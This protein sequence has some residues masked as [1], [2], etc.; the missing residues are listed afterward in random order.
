MSLWLVAAALALTTAAAP[1]DLQRAEDL[2]AK[3]K[4]ADASKALAKARQTKGLDRPSLLRILELQGIVAGQLRQAGP[5]LEAFKQL[6]VLDPTHELDA[7]YAP[8][9]TTPFMEAGQFVTEQGSLEVRAGT[10][11]TTATAV[12]SISVQVGRDPLKL[13]RSVVFHVASPG[14]WKVTPAELTGGLATLAVDGAEVSWWAELLGDNDAQLALVGSEAHPQVIAPPPP[15]ALT[16]TITPPLPPLS[17]SEVRA[18]PGAPIRTASYFV[19]GGAVASAGVG[20]FFGIKSQGEYSQLA[21]AERDMNGVIT[22]LTEQQ[23][24]AVAQS[25]ARDGA[26]ANAC[27]LGAGALAVSGGLMWIFGGPPKS[28]AVLPAP[29]GVVVSGRFP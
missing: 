17:P 27:F 12:T 23:A 19:L 28:V 16:P 11:E 14:G 18:A 6:L 21:N 5:A 10:A 3:Y 2:A 13:A 26:I 20:V 25:A 4:Y 29:G 9:V 22:G 15:V 7:E 8:R 1:A 24:N